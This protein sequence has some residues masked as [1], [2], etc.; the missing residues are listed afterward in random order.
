MNA[1]APA[2]RPQGTGGGRGLTRRVLAAG[3][4]ALGLAA[5]WRLPL[6][7]FPEPRYPTLA[8]DLALATPRMPAEVSRLWVV[9]LEA[10]LHAVGGVRSVAASVEAN[11]AHLVAEL[12]PATDVDTKAARLSG[13][14]RSLRRRLPEGSS[15]TVDTAARAAGQ[16]TAVV[17]ISGP[18]A[19][20]ILEAAA[21]RLRLQPGINAVTT[22]G[23]W[24]RHTHVAVP[25]GRPEAAELARRIR[26][27]VADRLDTHRLGTTERR[28][29]RQPVVDGDAEQRPLADLP[30]DSGDGVLPLAAVAAVETR[31]EPPQ[32]RVRFAGRPARALIVR[33][34]PSTS[35]LRADA[36]LRTTLAAV[37]SGDGRAFVSWS[38]AA[39]LHQLL[40]RGALALLAACLLLAAAGA[41]M[42]GPRGLEIT[43]APLLGVAAAAN[44][45]WLAGIPVDTASATASLLAVVVALPL[46]LLR[47]TAPTA[48][49]LSTAALAA[50]LAAFLPL[51][52]SFAGGEIRW[53]LG[54]PAFTFFL[55]VAGSCASLLLLPGP[56]AVRRGSGRRSGAPLRRSLRDPATALLAG[57]ALAYALLVVAGP[58]LAQHTR[59]VPRNPAD[60]TIH[61]ILASGSSAQ[62]SEREVVAVE[63]FLATSPLVVRQWS[64]IQAQDSFVFVELTPRGRRPEGRTRLEA[65][66]HA[67]VATSAQLDVVAGTGSAAA[68]GAPSASAD[69]FSTAWDPADASFYRVV[70]R[71]ADLASL[72]EAYRRVVLRLGSLDVGGAEISGWDR[73]ALQLQLAPRAGVTSDEWQ[74]WIA[75]LARRASPPQPLVL[76]RHPRSELTVGVGPERR[77]WVPP[78][79]DDLLEV[80]SRVVAGHTGSAL[81]AVEERLV[82]PRVARLDGRFVVPLTVRPRQ[83]SEARRR[84]RIERIEAALAELPLPAGATVD[85]PDRTA[86]AASAGPGGG[87]PFAILAALL[88]LAAATVRTGTLAGPLV[89]LLPAAL[90]VLAPAFWILWTLG[91]SDGTTVIAL[92]GAVVLT[93]ATAVDL[94]AAVARTPGDAGMPAAVYRSFR[95]RLA[96]SVGGSVVAV[97]TLLPL[98]VG[99]EPL[100][101]AWT[102]PAG[103]M[104][105]GTAAGTAAVYLLLPAGLAALHLARRRWSQDARHRR[106]P[107]AWTTPA[108]PPR[109]AVR[110][111]VKV[112]ANGH[113]ALRG[114][115]L[116]LEPGVV[117]LLGPNGAGKTTFMRTL[118]GLLQHTRGQVRFRG[119]TVDV[120][121]QASYRSH[122]GFLPQELHAY[123]GITGEQF[124][125][126]WAIE[127]GIRSA[128]ERRREIARVLELVELGEHADR[129]V[130]GYSGGM[131]RRIGIAQALLGEPPVLVVDEPTAGM[132]LESRLQLR[133]VL[134]RAAAGRIVLIS[135]HLI[136]DVD[137]LANRLLF[138]YAGRLFYDGPQSGFV[139]A[140]PGGVS[141]LVVAAERLDELRGRY[142]VTR[143]VH[144]TDGVEVR[145]LTREPAD[146]PGTPV[147]P[148]L[149]EAYLLHLDS[150]RRLQNGLKR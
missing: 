132:D 109:L 48:R 83:L 75:R 121:N 144:R 140:A 65:D 56:L 131:Q 70:L 148:T 138:L 116:V 119:V 101:S 120:H 86:G 3:L 130:R 30:I 1:G 149:E 129:R 98:A 26:D 21:R 135:T 123:P 111:L 134:Q 41:W 52:N 103:V 113:R 110:N 2:T 68:A 32:T 115:D 15:L 117:G 13:P 74:P 18:R 95:A 16:V 53:S 96:I 79:L 147:E 137:A 128:G 73:P 94:V 92:A 91:R 93:G 22:L 47:L 133:R 81:F 63:H 37:V 54:V 90:A 28:G 42:V 150:A 44:L 99:S 9:P 55:T 60:L 141:E 23:S 29:R 14:L 102:V 80:P 4:V 5:A 126:L 107:A 27:T 46:A 17:W 35:P 6:R 43:L 45:L 85:L 39:P 118:V 100:R 71:S 38:E 36:I 77:P 34:E 125:E 49:F 67:T 122:I 142:R 24:E 105:L 51:V 64:V 33:R 10:A 112:Y 143:Q 114:I 87:W 106:R 124:L 62:R 20:A 136:S 19:D 88:L 59:P 50:V 7:T 78:R 84:E 58:A 139:A 127:K 8:L 76:S 31:L 104:A 97:G 82:H 61:L 108:G 146:Q 89:V 40:L 69:R 11:G 25:P 145:L 72:D 66:L 57:L 12:A